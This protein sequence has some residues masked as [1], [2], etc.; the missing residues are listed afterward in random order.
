MHETSYQK[1]NA[2]SLEYIL[3]NKYK[4]FVILRNK[5]MQNFTCKSQF[6][7]NLIAYKLVDRELHNVNIY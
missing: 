4:I 6:K 3:L 7:D 1:K 2:C 5:R